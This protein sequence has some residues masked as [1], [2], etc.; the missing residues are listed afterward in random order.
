MDAE[1]DQLRIIRLHKR[2]A[3]RYTLLSQ[4]LILILFAAIYFLFDRA[5]LGAAERVGAFVLL[6]TI[7][8]ATIIWQALGLAIAR[9]HML[10]DGLDLERLPPALDPA[11]KVN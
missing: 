8:L 10:H 7:I 2:W 3:D 6:G 1:T 4:A 11:D 5:G 9:L